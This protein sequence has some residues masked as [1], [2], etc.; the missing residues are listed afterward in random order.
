[1]D[2]I[3]KRLSQKGSKTKPNSKRKFQGIF[4]KALLVHKNL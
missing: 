2:G 1:M 3:I 4:K